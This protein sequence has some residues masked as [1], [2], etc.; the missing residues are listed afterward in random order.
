[1][2]F[3]IA[4]LFS[5]LLIYIPDKLIIFSYIHSLQNFYLGLYPIKAQKTS[6]S[7]AIFF[8]IRVNKYIRVYAL[9]NFIKIFPR[10]KKQAT[11]TL[12]KG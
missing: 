10:I 6:N 2:Q 7:H 11:K 3:F 4:I 8:N 12:E 5:Q 9:Y 1:M